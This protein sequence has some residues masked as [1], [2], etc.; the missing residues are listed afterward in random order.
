MFLYVDLAARRAAAD[1]FKEALK[2]AFYGM[3]EARCA[4]RMPP[5]SGPAATATA[6]PLHRR[7]AATCATAPLRLPRL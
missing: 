2:Y 1:R 4:R 3:Q 6:Q 7:P 5:P